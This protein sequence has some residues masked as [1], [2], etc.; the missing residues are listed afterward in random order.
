MKTA[1][2]LALL[3]AGC[4]QLPKGVEMTDDERAAC[5]AQGCSVWTLAELQ[6]LVQIAAKRGYDMGR[7][8][9]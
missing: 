4:A 3:L 8:S 2:V 1:I 5:E 6:K 7:K 9:L